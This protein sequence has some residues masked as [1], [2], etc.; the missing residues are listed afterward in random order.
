MLEMFIVVILNIVMSSNDAPC[1]KRLDLCTC[2]GFIE[3]FSEPW[4][5]QSSSSA[6]CTDDR[7]KIQQ[8]SLRMTKAIA[9]IN[10]PIVGEEADKIR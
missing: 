3:Y 5:T 7:N 1:V 9:A 6:V 10:H 2:Y 4:L 8:A